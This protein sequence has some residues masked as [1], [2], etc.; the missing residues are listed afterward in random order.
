MLR[1]IS[2]SVCSVLPHFQLA[3]GL[4]KYRNDSC[5]NIWNIHHKPGNELGD[6]QRYSSSHSE[7]SS[8][9]HT[10]YVEIGGKSLHTPYTE[11][12][13]K[14]LHTPYLEIGGKSIHTPYIDIR[15]K[16]LHTSYVEIGNNSIH[17][18]NNLKR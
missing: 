9:I 4:E 7:S 14:S 8:A 5:I 1:S 11:I 2:C 18:T 17:Y 12:G 16:S 15:S 13:G 10:P 3:E 6:R